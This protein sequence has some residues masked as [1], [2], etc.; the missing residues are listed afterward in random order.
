MSELWE[1]NF[2]SRPRVTCLATS[3]NLISGAIPPDQHTDRAAPSRGGDQPTQPPPSLSDATVPPNSERAHQD[4]SLID[5]LAPAQADDEIGRLGGFRI[6]KVL[7][8]G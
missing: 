3:E 5:F 6:L 8:H 2:N 7:G 4:A 1:C